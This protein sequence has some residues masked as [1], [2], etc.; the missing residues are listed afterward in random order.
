MLLS[1]CGSIPATVAVEGELSTPATSL[2]RDE[3]PFDESGRYREDWVRP[4]SKGASSTKRKTTSAVTSKPAPISPQVVSFNTPALQ[5]EPAVVSLTPEVPRKRGLHRVSTGDTLWSISRR[6]G[7]TVAALKT[8]NGITE[9]LIQSG[10]TLL[11]P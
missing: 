6:Y 5:P 2:P 8:E 7:V 4:P 11:I 10:T 1:S 9:D 3:Y